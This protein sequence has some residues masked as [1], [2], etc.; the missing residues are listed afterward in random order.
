MKFDIIQFIKKINLAI[1]LAQFDCLFWLKGLRSFAVSA[2]IASVFLVKNNLPPAL[3]AAAFLQ[4]E[5]NA[6]YN[7]LFSEIT[8]HS[9]I[10]GLVFC[11][12]TTSEER[13]LSSNRLFRTAAVIDWLFWRKLLRELVIKDYP[14]LSEQ[15]SFLPQLAE[16]LEDMRFYG[17]ELE[18]LGEYTNQ[19]SFACEV[20]VNWHLTDKPELYLD[21]VDSQVFTSELNFEA[22]ENLSQLYTF[23]FYEKSV[24][25]SC[26]SGF[27]VDENSRVNMLD[28]DYWYPVDSSLRRYAVDYIRQ[29]AAPQNISEC[30][31]RRSIELLRRFCPLVDINA[32]FEECFARYPLNVPTMPV[33]ELSTAELPP[34]SAPLAS[35]A[36]AVKDA[37][38][39]A[40][41]HLLEAPSLHRE[42]Q[43]RKSSLWYFIPL[44]LAIC[45]LLKF[46]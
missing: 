25:A 20:A 21:V 19:E 16:L 29:Q 27:A 37:A 13:I 31:L 46:F 45:L 42:T 43:F 32:V 30:R 40:L 2:K 10:C 3:K 36:F 23:L 41:S 18:R 26:F 6:F 4:H 24:F 22:Q 9:D 28:F 7:L 39:Q 5:S 11:P 8:L 15:L 35:F 17:A 1:R 14:C 44:V 38:P 34:A 33:S 12:P